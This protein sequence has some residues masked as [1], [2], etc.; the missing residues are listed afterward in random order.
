VLLWTLLLLFGLLALVLQITPLGGGAP[1]AMENP[2]SLSV[3]ILFG[4]TV[5]FGVVTLVGWKLSRAP[6]GE[7]FPFR[8]FR[9]MILVPVLIAS[10]G[11]VLVGAA[12]DALLRMLP[13]PEILDTVMTDLEALLLRMFREAFWPALAAVVV[14]APFTEELFFRGLLL[15]G[16]RGR[17]RAWSAIA[18]SSTF[19]AAAHL[20]SLNQV[21]VGFAAGLFLGWLLVRSG[22]LWLPVVAHAAFNAQP[23]IA[24]R[25]MVPHEVAPDP[26]FDPLLLAL[27][28][29]LLVGGIGFIRRLT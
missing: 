14:M 17:Y 26:T 15:H 22:N 24:A 3:L 8:R 25:W 1:E 7:M 5:A 6:L 13:I 23:A 20:P 19:F 9:P 16:F 18:L 29:L 12:V 28:A 2:L 21:V 10:V 27:G 11:A 4:N